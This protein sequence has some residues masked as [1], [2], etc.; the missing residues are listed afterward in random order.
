[1]EKCL[2]GSTTVYTVQSHNQVL[3]AW[4]TC[5]GLNVFSLDYHTDTKEAFGS[6]AYWRTDSELKA[7]S[8]GNPDV[9]RRELAQDKIQAY[10]DGKIDIRG[11]ND[12]L[13]HDE[14]MDFAVRSNIISSAFV[15]S[16]NRNSSSSNPYVY[17]EGCDIE[18]SGQPIM[19]YSM[20]CIPGCSRDSHD[21]DCFRR[22]RDACIDDSVLSMAVGMA[23]SLNPGFFDAFILDIDC[24]YF[25]TE[26]SLHPSS[27]EVFKS[28]IRKAALVTIALEPECVKIC[29]MEGCQLESRQI[30]DEL[31]I[32]IGNA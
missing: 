19:E 6:Y 17:I 7:G 14:H 21:Q 20:P 13:K 15:L 26:E 22:Y 4:E 10:L 2:A 24:D 16:V 31:K 11:I 9:R 28:L 25:N 18:Y 32:I 3:E 12:N 27:S 23:E 30:A 29:R 5:P 8:C 1:M